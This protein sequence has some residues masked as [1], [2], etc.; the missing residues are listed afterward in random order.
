[1]LTT[2]YKNRP[3]RSENVDWSVLLKVWLFLIDRGLTSELTTNQKI[4]DALGI[5]AGTVK[6][7]RRALQKDFHA[8]MSRTVYEYDPESD[9]PFR[10]LGSEITVTAWITDDRQSP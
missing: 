3:N 10:C 1:M 6:N 7:A 5:K 8:I 2:K 9:Q 4:G